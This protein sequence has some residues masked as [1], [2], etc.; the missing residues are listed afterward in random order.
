MA[1]AT[2]IVSYNVLEA[3]LASLAE[4]A[5]ALE[6]AGQATP[7]AF[8]T[9]RQ[10]LELRRD[11]LQIQVDTGQL[12]MEGYLQQLR[13]AI[14]REKARSAAFK[15]QK[16]GARKALEAYKRAKVMQDELEEAEAAEAGD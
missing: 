15:A 14:P 10:A 11:F 9:R 13:E 16:G 7:F 4:R 6:A 2:R 1:F 12:T 8:D 3:E 5:K